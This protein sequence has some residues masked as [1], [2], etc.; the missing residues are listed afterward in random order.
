MRNW[1]GAI[2]ALAFLTANQ[3]PAAAQTSSD[4][5]SRVA[6]IVRQTLPAGYNV[7][8]SGPLTI[9]VAAHGMPPFQ[10]NL[11]NINRL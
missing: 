4:I 8:I 10:V 6:K 9:R 5:T 11:D 2:A 3:A 7:T 1:I